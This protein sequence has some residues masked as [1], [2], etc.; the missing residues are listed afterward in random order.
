MNKKI[1]FF[2]LIPFM[3]LSQVQIGQNINGEAAGDN[4]YRVAISSNGDILAIGAPHNA[5]NGYNAGNVR[6][7]KN[8]SGSWSQVGNDIDGESSSDGCGFSVSLSSD[9]SIVAIG[10]YF[11]KE[12]GF[13]SGHVRVYKNISGVWTQIGNDINGEL[14]DGS[15]YSIALSSDGSIVAIGSPQYTNSTNY[16]K[17]R[18]FKNISGAWNQIGNNIN[19]KAIGD[20]TGQSVSLSFNGDIVAIG[21]P[22]KSGN[23]NDRGRVY[24][25]KNISGN[26]IQIGGDIEG[27]AVGDQNGASV[28]ISSDGSIVAIGA[29]ENDSNGVSSGQVRVYQ[30]LSNVWTQIGNNING[31]TAG[32]RSGSIVSSV[33]L[34]SSGNIL[35]IG[36]PFNDGNGNNSG[37]VRVY[38]KLSNVWTKVGIDIDGEKA[39]DQSGAS[40][41]LSSNG[42]VLA[43]GAPGNNGN[44]IGS[45][46]VRVFDLSGILSN[47]EF[48]LQNF[49]IYP[50]PTTDI[51]NISLKSNLISEQVII[52]N[53]LGQVVKKSNKNVIDVSHLTKGLYFVE[54]T[55][56][57][58][59]A[60]KK[61]IIN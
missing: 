4:S 58:G 46:H 5:G 6:I 61:I 54:V 44:G 9:G 48:V 40:V 2:L 19:G 35:A 45:G 55:T 33:S 50:N 8:V 60:T 11:N 3:G 27:E 37:H 59:K 15:G 10:A 56:N 1:L 39:G 29:P 14:Q 34:S 25:Y 20:R 30:N 13:Y 16:G 26:W 32:D 12:N 36:A 21:A 24:V 47:N 38:Q 7:Y 31:E 17:V 22:G 42:N 51:L 49:S 18:V 23:V 43:I 53:D 52:Y 41:A 28:S 57:Q